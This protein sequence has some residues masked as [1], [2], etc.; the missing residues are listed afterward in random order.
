MLQ[1]G[2]AQP[3]RAWQVFRAS[4]CRLCHHYHRR[5]F[6]FLPLQARAG[7]VWFLALPV[8]PR[9]PIRWQSPSTRLPQLPKADTHSPSINAKLPRHQTRRSNCG[10]HR[11]IS[12]SPTHQTPARSQPADQTMR[13]SFIEYRSPG[14]E[15]PSPTTIQHHISPWY[16]L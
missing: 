16:P 13:A 4:A 3:L 9:P 7:G 5:Q 14:S 6:Y 15:A 12:R 2:V 8:R 11:S 1:R 10:Q